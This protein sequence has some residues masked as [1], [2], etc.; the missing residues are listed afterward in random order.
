M[1]K[2]VSSFAE[3]LTARLLVRLEFYPIEH[4]PTVLTDIATLFVDILELP[5]GPDDIDMLP[6]PSDD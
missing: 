4:H 2:E 1:I 3:T 5:Q 6:S